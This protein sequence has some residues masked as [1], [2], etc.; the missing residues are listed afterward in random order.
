MAESLAAVVRTKPP[1][2]LAA[3]SQAQPHG[4]EAHII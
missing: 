3:L 2:H 1:N 4:T